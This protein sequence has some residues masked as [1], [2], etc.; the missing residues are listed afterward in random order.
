MTVPMKIN[1]QKVLCKEAPSVIP[2][3]K[4]EVNIR[5]TTLLGPLRLIDAF[6][7]DKDI[8]IQYKMKSYTGY[9]VSHG[10]KIRAN[11]SMIMEHV[12]IVARENEGR[13]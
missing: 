2:T 3:F 10:Q 6:R 1:G 5:I 4:D 9:I 12:I 11:D 8:Q 7:T 13:A